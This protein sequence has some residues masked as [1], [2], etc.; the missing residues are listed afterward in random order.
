MN[1]D[2]VRKSRDIDVCS[3]F[4][5][6]EESIGGS[7]TWTD[8][9]GWTRYIDDFLL[10]LGAIGG[11]WVSETHPKYIFQKRKLSQPCR[12]SPFVSDRNFRSVKVILNMLLEPITA[13]LCV[14]VKSTAVQSFSDSV[15][16]IARPH[17]YALQEP[18]Y[19][20]VYWGKKQ[21]KVFLK[22]W[23]FSKKLG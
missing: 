18:N 15:L 11:K 23:K 21:F 4:A 5:E 16:P 8:F 20:D 19:S 13:Y 10:K 7:F 12:D 1:L 6:V 2:G 14:C 9:L 17:V 22:L 3:W